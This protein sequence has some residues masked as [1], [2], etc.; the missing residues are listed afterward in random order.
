MVSS[1]NNTGS[2]RDDPYWSSMESSFKL[3]ELSNIN[4]DVMM[5]SQHAIH[6]QLSEVNSFLCQVFA[7]HQARHPTLGRVVPKKQGKKFW[8][9]DSLY[10]E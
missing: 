8:I 2:I 3:I 7:A 10:N 5:F 9:T 1:Q 4:D 6:T